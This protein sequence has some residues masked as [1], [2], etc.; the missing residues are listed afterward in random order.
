MKK[1]MYGFQ[2][3]HT[4]IIFHGLFEAY[5]CLWKKW[6]DKKAKELGFRDRGGGGEAVTAPAQGPREPGKG[7]GICATCLPWE[8]PQVLRQEP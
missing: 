6:L 3:F 1:Y 4:K 7:F 5:S 2:F 8:L